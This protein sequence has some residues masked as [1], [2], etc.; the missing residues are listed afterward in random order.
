MDRRTYKRGGGCSGEMN[1]FIGF[2][3]LLRAFAKHKWLS[4]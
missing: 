1:F 2:S 3:A 4:L